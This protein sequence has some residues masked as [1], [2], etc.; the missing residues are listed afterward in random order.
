[1][2]YLEGKISKYTPQLSFTC[3][4]MLVCVGDDL[5]LKSCPALC[6]LMDCSPAGASVHGVFQAHEY[7]SRLSFPSPGDLPNRGMEL[8]SP[9]SQVDS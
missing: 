4:C 6:D 2:A 5:V 1:M 7:W 9:A 3:V 8:R